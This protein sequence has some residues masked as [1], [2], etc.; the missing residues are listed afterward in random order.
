MNH[1]YWGMRRLWAAALLVAP[2]MV[3]GAGMTTHAAM[4]DHGRQALPDGVLKQI[5]SAHRPALLAGAIYPD[6]GYGSGAAFPADR[7]MAERAHWGEFHVAFM[8]YLREIGCGA[9]A[10]RLVNPPVPA[11][12]ELPGGTVGMP[13]GTVDLAGLTDA[14]GQLIAFAFGVAAHGV[15]DE[16]WDA[17]FEPEVRRH[18]EDPNLAAHLDADGFWGPFTPGSVLR[19]IVG[20]DRY[21]YLHDLYAATPMNGIEYAM[22]VVHIVDH[23]LPLDAPTLV[24]PPA[25]HLAAVYR[26][27]GAAVGAEQI[28]RGNLF[29]RGAVQAQALTAPADYERVRAHMPW[30]AHN[31]YLA[32]GGVVSSGQVV[33]GMYR[34]MWDQLTGDPARPQPA[35]VVGHYPRHGVVEVMLEPAAGRS[36]TQHRWLHVFFGN[37]VDPESIELPGAFCLFDEAGER[38]DVTV[39]GGHGWSRYGS[40]STRV[41][42]DVPLK[43][44]HRYTAVLTTKIRDYKG[45][46]LARPYSWQFVTAAQ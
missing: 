42:L 26:R 46:P 18:G 5:L 29:S 35:H 4:A 24:F 38:V 44:D 23:K 13:V 8:E 32:D 22:D 15:T 19:Q 31:Y 11:P 25:A 3:Q 10:A 45:Q 34:Q 30:A 2:A 28:E 16:T 40:H 36:W 43:P 9:Q 1:R 39:Q 21:H 37:E 7:D 41:R 14:C 17:L 20:A 33:A 12:V 27:S 6:G